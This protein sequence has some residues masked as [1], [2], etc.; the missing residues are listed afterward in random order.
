VVTEYDI[1]RVG[2]GASFVVAGTEIMLGLLWAGGSAPFPQ[3][4]ELG[5]LDVPDDLL[6]GDTATTIRFRQWTVVFGFEL[7]R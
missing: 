7:S 6:S 4:F 3:L 5:D 1:N 2:G